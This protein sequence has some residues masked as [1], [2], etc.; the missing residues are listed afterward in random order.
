MSDVVRR[1]PSGVSLYLHVPFCARK[2]P[3]CDFNT[4]AGRESRYSDTV[5]ALCAEMERRS[6]DALGRA[7]ETVFIGGG[8][9]TVLSEADLTRLIGS[10]ATNFRLAPG[11]EMT[12]EANPGSA[13]RAKFAVLRSLGVN[14][15]SIGV[16][17]FQPDELR[18]LG[19]VHDVDDATRAFDAARAAGFDNVSLDLMFGLP[20]QPLSAWQS[21]LRTALALGPDHISLYSLIVEPGTPLATWV[22]SGTVGA[23]D[24][25]EA[26]LHYEA[27]IELMAKAGYRHYEVSNWARDFGTVAGFESRHNLVYWR[28]GDWI[29]IG[30]GAHGHSRS[31]A[32]SGEDYSERRYGNLRPVDGY[33]ARVRA[34]SPLAD[35]D[36]AIDPAT[37]R[38]E[39][40]MLGLRL[41][42]EG[43]DR[44]RFRSLHGMDPTEAFGAEIDEL[45][46]WGLLEVQPDRIRLTERGLFLGNQV[47]ERFVGSVESC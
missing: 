5:S 20:D 45:A 16:Q 9:P 11:A 19:R 13:D 23:P 18:F 44:D 38:G 42:E 33:V 30:P 43:V 36:E 28:N 21:T 41:V 17:S 4:Y 26:A 15:I 12:C 35:V 31:L 39:S 3:Y 2:C 27:A 7:V 29:G 22:A 34:G 46:D 37:A 25:D 8:T 32:P 40:M 1:I 10:V 6:D 24:E 47:F 14:R